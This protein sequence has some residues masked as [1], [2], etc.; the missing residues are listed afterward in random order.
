MWLRAAFNGMA[1]P[2]MARF[3]AAGEEQRGVAYDDGAQADISPWNGI[4]P[5]SANPAGVTPPFGESAPLA[6]TTA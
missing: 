5:T 2:R 4:V 3:R 6:W 1:K